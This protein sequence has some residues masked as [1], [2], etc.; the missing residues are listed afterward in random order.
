MFAMSLDDVI[1]KRGAEGERVINEL[2]DYAAK[3]RG[4]FG[5]LTVILY[6]SYARGDF[7]L[8]SDVD[9]LIIS[10]HFRGTDFVTRCVELNDAPP[11]LE[12]I[13]WTPEEAFKALAKPWWREVLKHH[14]VIIDDYKIAKLLNSQ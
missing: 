7:N 10:G 13:C 1:R 11:K 6:G 5:R 4:R 9:V 2:R 8:W 3:L 12:P 14:V